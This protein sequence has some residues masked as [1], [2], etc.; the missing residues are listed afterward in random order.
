MLQPGSS[1]SPRRCSRKHAH[2]PHQQQKGAHNQP[3][4]TPVPVVPAPVKSAYMASGGTG[5][6]APPPFVPLSLRYT[7]ARAGGL[8]RLDLQQ[9]RQPDCA[10]TSPSTCAVDAPGAGG[11]LVVPPFAPFLVVSSSTGTATRGGIGRSDRRRGANPLSQH[12][13]RN[14]TRHDG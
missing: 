1:P 9:G 14:T 12:Q 6:A 5:A 2:P 7:S 11:S 3:D 13:H 8:S 10:A 4:I